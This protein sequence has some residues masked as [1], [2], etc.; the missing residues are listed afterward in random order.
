MKVPRILT[1]RGLTFQ[2][3]PNYHDCSHFNQYEIIHARD[4]FGALLYATKNYFPIFHD[5]EKK[6]FAD[7]QKINNVC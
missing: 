3:Q 1:D 4:H 7:E 6:T 2:K 5:E